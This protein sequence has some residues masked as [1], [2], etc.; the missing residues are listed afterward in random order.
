[1]NK[2]SAALTTSIALALGVVGVAP[3]NAIRLDFDK[4]VDETIE[5]YKE[6]YILRG[7]EWAEWGINI[8]V[9][10]KR[11][12][13]RDGGDSRDSELLTLYNTDPFKEAREV[14]QGTFLK[15]AH[16][17]DDLRTGAPWGTDAQGNVLIVQANNKNDKQKVVDENGADAGKKRVN[18]NEKT[19][20]GRYKYVDD[21]ARGAKI[22]FDFLEANENYIYEN[23]KLG[24]LDIDNSEKSWVTVYYLDGEG[25]EQSQQLK[26]EIESEIPSYVDTGVSLLSREEGD[27]SLWEFN[28]DFLNQELDSLMSISKIEVEYK[29][30]GGIAYVDYDRIEKAIY[31]DG[32]GD[33]ARVPEPSSALALLAVGALGGGSILKCKQ[34]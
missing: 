21:D 10:A 1:M 27:N 24:L 30:S 9:D 8:S 16:L 31:G 29:A 20:D 34:Q 28:F 3:A 4:N 33:S 19:E 13:F 6:G 32:E 25:Q 15:E 23:L 5:N 7:D 12:G 26:L 14:G 11:N 18:R 22:T 2:L 17:D